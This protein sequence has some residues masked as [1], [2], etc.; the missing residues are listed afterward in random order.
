ML[1]LS[2]TGN[3]ESKNVLA[4]GILDG[5]LKGLNGDLNLLWDQL[6]D[7]WGVCVGQGRPDGVGV[8]TVNHL[9]SFEIVN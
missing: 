8:T 9:S 2:Q 4:S 5:V 6:G 3:V 7:L 1:T